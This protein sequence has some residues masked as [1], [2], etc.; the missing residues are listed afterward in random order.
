MNMS[1][2]LLGLFLSQTPFAQAAVYYLSPTGAD[3]SSG[4][5]AAAPWRTFAFA[6]PKLSPGDTLI[7]L[8]GTYTLQNSGAAAID[9][10]AT[11]KNGASTA[12]ITVR[13][14]NE[15]RAFLSGNGLYNPFVMQNCSYW[16]IEG[17]RIESADA[18][19]GNTWTGTPISLH[20]SRNLIVRR[21]LLRHDNR[22]S[23][24]PLLSGVGL[25]ASLIEEL[26]LYEYH[27]HGIA[28]GSD[29]TIRRVYCNSRDWPDLPGGRDSGG[30][31]GDSCVAFYP[32]S[33]NLVEN[34]IAENNSTPVTIQATSP[35]EDNR[36]FGVISIRNWAGIVVK[37]RGDSG[38]T[39]MPRN[40][41]IRDFAAINTLYGLYARGNHNTRC[42]RCSFITGNAGLVADREIAHGSLPMTIYL[43][44]SLATGQAVYG[45]G[46]TGDYGDWK[47]DSPAAF[48]NAANFTMGA[49]PRIVNAKLADPKLGTCRV[50]IPDGSPLKRAGK[51]GEDIGANI[52]YRYQDGVLT[53]QPLWDP[54]T[55]RFPCGAV[56]PGVNDVAGSSC[57]DVH[58]R[59]NVNSN[60]CP[61]P[62]G[63]G[64]GTAVSN[65]APA[66]VRN[67]SL[68]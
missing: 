67:A 61:F 8:D 19:A 39:Q 33:R 18:D 35:A 13:S 29:N 34:L 40:T 27:R 48:A 38:T 60:G 10:A 31:G 62:A 43:D 14:Q 23:N 20:N 57:I 1:A 44:N 9:C 24:V 49:D 54:S 17:L 42:E 30:V 26:E 32:G 36:L 53:N 6:T 28:V 46:I 51:N 58:L 11:H 64:G 68:R 65:P 4:L 2:A 7:L 21:L 63:Y 16:T 12:R 59:L 66:A 25:N 50:W 56:V 52:L 47:L 55:G 15:R 37:A 3:G 5:S 41:L 22:Y 45:F